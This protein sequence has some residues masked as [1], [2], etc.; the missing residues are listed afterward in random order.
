MKL[1]IFPCSLTSS[2]VFLISLTDHAIL[3]ETKILGVSL[4]SFLFYIPNPIHQ[5]ILWFYLQNRSIIKTRPR[6]PSVEILIYTRLSLNQL[7]RTLFSPLAASLFS[8]P[9][10]LADLTPATTCSACACLKALQGLFFLLGLLFPRYW[11]ASLLTLSSSPRCHFS[12]KPS[13]ATVSSNV[14]CSH[15]SQSPF[16]ALFFSKALSSHL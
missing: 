1:L 2:Q 16:S 13:L 15:H 11:W 14:S 3:A 10:L 8:F 9:P 4:D 6:S 12:V 5:Q 7:H